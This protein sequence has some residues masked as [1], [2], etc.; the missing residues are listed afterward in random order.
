[1]VPGDRT[2]LPVPAAERRAASAAATPREGLSLDLAV[3]ERAHSVAERAHSVCDSVAERAHIIRA[4]AMGASVS[5]ISPRQ[6]STTP[7]LRQASQPSQPQR[8]P[9]RDPVQQRSGPAVQRSLSLAATAGHIAQAVAAPAHSVSPV[10]MP[11]SA[12]MF[13]SPT[14]GSLAAPG[15]RSRTISVLQHSPPAGSPALHEPLQGRSRP[16]MS[17]PPRAGCGYSSPPVGSSAPPPPVSLVGQASRARSFTPAAS[18]HG[19]LTA[20]AP[21]V[22]GR[23]SPAMPPPALSAVAA[24]ATVHVR[25]G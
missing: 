15:G 19:S 6:G 4:Q 11:Q 21:Q 13:G 8:S 9:S 24:A 7:P 23:F 16:S 20:P 18:Q 25:H 2:G 17:P 3:V 12:A 22:S 1:V 10:C 5:R 14:H